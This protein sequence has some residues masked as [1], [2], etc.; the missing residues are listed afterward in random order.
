[1]SAQD[2]V[3]EGEAVFFSP[4]R[5]KSAWSRTEGLNLVAIEVPLSFCK[6][7]VSQAKLG[8]GQ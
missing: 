6:S 3:V 4:L 8:S 1:L 5:I 2:E 7:F